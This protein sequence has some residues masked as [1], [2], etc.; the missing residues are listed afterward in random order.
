MDTRSWRDRVQ[1]EEELLHQLKA[2]TSE[3][4]KRRAAALAE[5]VVELGTVAAVAKELGRSHTA[6]DNA[7]KRHGPAKQ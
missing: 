1:A 7:I 2:Q 4:A 3:A 6:I 5:G